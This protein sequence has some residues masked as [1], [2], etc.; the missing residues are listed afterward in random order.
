MEKSFAGMHGYLLAS[1]DLTLRKPLFKIP[2]GLTKSRYE[3]RLFK[4]AAPQDRGLVF[5]QCA[6]W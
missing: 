4:K 5:L 2:E 1:S 3:P 6:L